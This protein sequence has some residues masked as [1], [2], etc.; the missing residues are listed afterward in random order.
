MR[1]G[2]CCKQ[3]TNPTGQAHTMIAF[4][5]SSG[6]VTVLATVLKLARV[7]LMYRAGR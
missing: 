6:A 1:V 3:P 2:L 5:S 4:L 7:Y